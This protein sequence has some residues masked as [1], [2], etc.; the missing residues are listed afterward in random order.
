MAE[1]LPTCH[2][3][4][5]AMAL[6]W[7]TNARAEHRSPIDCTKLQCGKRVDVTIRTRSAL[8]SPIQPVSRSEPAKRKAQ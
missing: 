7:L 6:A 5:A 3:S 1:W 4:R 2:P 8:T